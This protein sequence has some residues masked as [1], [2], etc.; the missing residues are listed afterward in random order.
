MACDWLQAPNFMMMRFA[1]R[2]SKL[3]KL[4]KQAKQVMT[5]APVSRH[6]PGTEF[7][8]SA[9][10]P[11]ANTSHSNDISSTILKPAISHQ[12]V[13]PAMGPFSPGRGMA[14][15]LESRP[16]LKVAM[17]GHPGAGTRGTDGLLDVSP[18]VRVKGPRVDEVAP[19]RHHVAWSEY[20]AGA[21]QVRTRATHSRTL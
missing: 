14:H 17:Q 20:D 7:D 6:I 16:R 9:S 3:S 5:G 18:S 11:M 15:R 10:R 21:S 4:N 8:P 12:E 2:K 19:L 1:S 13:A